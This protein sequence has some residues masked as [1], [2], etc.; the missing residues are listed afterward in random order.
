MDI[1][2][3]LDH[4]ASQRRE[5]RESKVLMERWNKTGLLKGLTSSKARNMAILLNN[6][7][8]QVM[9][10]SNNN[11]STGDGAWLG[12]ALPLVRKV[13]GSIPAQQ[14]LSI[15]PMKTSAGLAFFLDF[16]Y[17]NDRGG[18]SKGESIYGS[19]S[20]DINGQ[21]VLKPEGGLYGSGA[22]DYSK[23][24]TKVAATGAAGVSAVVIDDTNVN[25]VT[26]D[27]RFIGQT[28]VFVTWNLSQIDTGHTPGDPASNI[29]ISSIQAMSQKIPDT[30]L[31]KD[32][33]QYKKFTSISADGLEVTMVFEND[34]AG[35]LPTVP[36][37]VTYLKNDQM[38]YPSGVT[39]GMGDTWSDY[40]DFDPIT[41]DGDPAASNGLNKGT[42]LAI[43]DIK[44]DFHKVPIVAKS[45]KLKASWTP[46][47]EQDIKEYQGVDAEKEVSDTISKYIEMEIDMELLEMLINGAQ[48]KTA[49]SAEI[50]MEW[51]GTKFV[52]MANAIYTNK[53]MWYETLGVK[54]MAVSNEI[55]RRTMRGG[56][57]FSVISPDVSAIFQSISGF[58]GK[59]NSDFHSFGVRESGTF[60]EQIKVYTNPYMTSNVMLLGYKG[61]GQFETGAVYAPYIPLVSTPIMYDPENGTPRKIF[62]TRYAKK[63]LR[64]EFYG[65]I[66][67]SGL[68]T[69]GGIL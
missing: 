32:L 5:A 34:S 18:K 49:W 59:E 16:V 43:A 63:L 58:T 57:N 17:G 11:M 66:M 27:S 6:Q 50:N 26:Q 40:E 30:V 53:A 67:I 64:P 10:E 21:S 9:K 69:V 28:L 54:V 55:H 44:M 65:V 35:S 2:K 38:E 20:Y 19:Y 24:V 12:V 45:R 25:L 47:F 31:P 52:S 4:E 39:Q 15:Q 68:E 3:F 29:D 51:D 37:E 13:F 41:G 42:S 33:Y 61:E 62:S 14:F 23:R 22:Y 7:A 48:I 60:K 1:S 56:A 8:K 46:E 36:N